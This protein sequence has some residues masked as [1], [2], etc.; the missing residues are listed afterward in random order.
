M[1]TFLLINVQ[2]YIQF[3]VLQI[4]S[5]DINAFSEQEAKNTDYEASL[6]PYWWK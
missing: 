1:N 2:K 4:L 6:F 5:W 3:L